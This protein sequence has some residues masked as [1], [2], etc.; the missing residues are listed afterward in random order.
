MSRDLQ[1]DSREVLGSQMLTL[2]GE[3]RSCKNVVAPGPSREQ[4]DLALQI[5]VCA[6]D[7]AALRV[8]RFVLIEQPDIVT[9]GDRAVDLMVARPEKPM[10]AEKAQRTREW[11]REVPLLIGLAHQIHHDNPKVPIIEQTLSMGAAVMN[12]QNAL[13]AMGF[14]SYWSSGL[15]T[16]TEEIP[17][18]LGFDSL[19]YAFV[20]YLAVGTPKAQPKERVM[21]DMSVIASWWQAADHP[22]D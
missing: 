8:W 21:P 12:L 18:W 5:A 4:I 6:P 2:L 16:F 1:Q 10:S 11:L 20:G 22:L 15:G 19:D 7:H 13:H 17:A 9:L 3:R 14:S